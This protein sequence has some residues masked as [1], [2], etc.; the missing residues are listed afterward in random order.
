MLCGVCTVGVRT[1]LHVCEFMEVSNI[2]NTLWHVPSTAF[3]AEPLLGLGED[4]CRIFIQQ[5]GQ[6]G[7]DEEVFISE[8][9]ITM[10][11]LSKAG[12]AIPKCDV[13]SVQSCVRYM[14]EKGYRKQIQMR[15][16]T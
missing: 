2:L 12:L 3:P 8:L 11:D 15:I 16:R 4:E 10:N 6:G 7:M 14:E 1:Y 5:M 13:V 9:H